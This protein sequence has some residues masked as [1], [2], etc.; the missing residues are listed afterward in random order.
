MEK[1][2]EE[3]SSKPLEI[4]QEQDESQLLLSGIDPS[5]PEQQEQLQK[6]RR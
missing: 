3:R 2:I 5:D 1:E 6:E 4:I